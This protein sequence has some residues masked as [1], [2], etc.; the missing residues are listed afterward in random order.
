MYGKLIPEDDVKQQIRMKRALQAVGGGVSQTVVSVIL[1]FSGGFRIEWQGFICLMLFLWTG[2]VALLLLIRLGIN[3]RLSDPSMTRE[4]VIWSILTLLTTVFFMDQFRPLMLMYFPIILL[5]GAFSMT[6]NQ[7]RATAA[8]MILG[9]IGVILTVY[10]LYPRILN[11]EYEIVV[12]LVFTLVIVAFSFVSNEISLLRKKL[13]LRNAELASAIEK[14]ER[15]ATT[16]ELTGLINRRHLMYVLRQ[17]KSVADRG[18]ISFC[19]CF[20]DIDR[21]KRIN[22]HLG[23]HVG[24]IVLKRFSS[25]VQPYLRTSDLFARFGGEEFVFVA[26]GVDLDGATVAADRIRRA[27]QALRFK[28]VAP[29]LALTVSGGVAQFR[30]NE[31]IESVLS[32]ADQALYLAKNRGRNCIK[33]EADLDV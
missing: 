13:H 7:Y 25:A 8:L 33:T 28:D 2:H 17:Q 24:D 16:D 3:R 22:D 12:A 4:M 10:K 27:I 5:Y 20:F 29:D 14:I 21:F 9:Y 31:K 23:H 26:I 18:G 30:C 32:R 15:M 19:V 11:I 6:P 1:F